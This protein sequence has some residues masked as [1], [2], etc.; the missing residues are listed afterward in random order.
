M[1]GM[2]CLM[3][4]FVDCVSCSP[5]LG[6]ESSDETKLVE[7][8]GV[9]D[10]DVDV[11]AKKREPGGW[12]CMPYIIGNETFERLASYGLTANFTVYLVKRFHMQQLVAVNVANVFNGTANF[13]PLLGAFLSDAY[14][15]RFRTLAYASFASL[16]GMVILTL[17]S[18]IRQ[19]RPP[20]C[21]Q[22]TALTGHCAGPSHAQLG[23]LILS[24][25]LLALGAG[26]I[27]P[28]S[29]PFGVDQFDKETEKGR[30]GLA[31]YFNWY[32]CTST[33]GVLIGMTVVVYIQ[34]SYSWTLGFSI[35][36]CLMVL[37]IAFF[38]LGTRLYVYVLPEGSV[39]SGVVHAFVAAIRKRRLQLPAAEDA[40]EQEAKLWLNKAAIVCDG[41]VKEDGSVANPW[42]LCS[43]QQVEEMKCLIRI[44][45][46][47]AAGIICFVA[48]AQQWTFAVLQAL[49]MDRH[50][51]PH[52]QI[53]AGS[54][55]TIALLTLTLFIPIYDQ[56]FVPLARRITGIESGITLLQRQGVGLVISV[57]SMVVAGLVEEKRRRSAI[58]HGGVSP[59]SALWLAPQ[60]VLLGVAEAFNAVGQIEFYN[61]Q[62]P[63]QMQ[64]IA[65][66]LF[67]CSVAGASY[68]SSIIVAV[69]HKSTGGDGRPSW[70]N[71]NINTGKLDYFYYVL[72]GMG[73]VNFAYFVVCAHSYRYKGTPETAKV[74]A[75]EGG[76]EG[77]VVP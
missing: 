52:F 77:K 59:L 42:R 33:A 34:D 29:L 9:V 3:R 44:I 65:G 63:E 74:E 17:T 62:F 16:L 18:A 31:S 45:P 26:G 4:S 67:Y 32:Y 21:S 38:F 1:G 64:S 58:A 70:L 2:K 13:A 75:G 22:S 51:G 60:L 68:L 48:L 71:D 19:L 49:T 43:V 30:H 41:E 35:P 55:A 27:R 40:A 54:F 53:P 57:F 37:S 61:R 46:V 23:V 12:K 28:C 20:S 25:A 73:A 11:E 6:N 69:I 39:F 5:F 7:G 47:W 50:L 72:A 24:L 56:L 66:S 10:V 15:G 36:T 76:G 8:G 14:W